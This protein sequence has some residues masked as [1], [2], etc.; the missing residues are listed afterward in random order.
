MKSWKTTL[1]GLLITFTGFVVF[2][3]SMFGGDQTPLFQICKYVTLGGFA[4]LGL[5]AK[6][7]DK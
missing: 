3:P 1:T 4:R 5:S 7:Y 6:D 2:S